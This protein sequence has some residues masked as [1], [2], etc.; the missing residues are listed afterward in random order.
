MCQLHDY[1]KKVVEPAGALSITALRELAKNRSLEGKNV[2]CVVTGGNI[3][4]ERWSDVRRRSYEHLGQEKEFKIAI[5]NT[6][7]ALRGVLENFVNGNQIVL[8]R[9]DHLE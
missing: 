4:M 3:G 5:Q 9:F 7:G 6:P 8:L 1:D 2:I